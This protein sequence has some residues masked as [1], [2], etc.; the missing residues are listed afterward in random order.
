MKAFHFMRQLVSLQT[1]T[2]LLMIYNE[3]LSLCPLALAVSWEITQ[4]LFINYDKFLD[5]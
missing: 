4:R 2:E 3:M 1:F 5:A